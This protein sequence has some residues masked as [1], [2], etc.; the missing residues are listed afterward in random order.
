[1]MTRYEQGFMSKCAEYGVD[2]R[3]LLKQAKLTPG[4]SAKFLNNV[5]NGK[6]KSVRHTVSGSQ[7]SI[8]SNRIQRI[9]DLLKRLGKLSDP[10]KENLEHMQKMLGE[11][12]DVAALADVGATSAARGTPIQQMLRHYSMGG[13]YPDTFAV[14]DLLR[15]AGLAKKV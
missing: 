11:A 13:Q 3:V 1:M 9:K 5:F 12:G 2:G 7:H 15:T 4:N 8:Y 6:Y 14:E 10:T